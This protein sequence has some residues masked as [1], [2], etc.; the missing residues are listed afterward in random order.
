MKKILKKIV[1][2]VLCASMATASICT[3]SAA[4]WRSTK[5]KQVRGYKLSAKANLP[6]WSDSQ[7]GGSWRTEASYAGSKDG[8]KLTNSWSFY[9]IGGTVSASYSGV[10]ASVTGHGTSTGGSFTAKGKTVK[11]N[12]YVYGTGL[13]FYVGLISTASFTKGNTYYSIST[14]I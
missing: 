6:Y 10:G 13:C 4:S 14:K 1:V 3:A 8:N 9:S 11:A 7:G 5:S 2:G 12:G